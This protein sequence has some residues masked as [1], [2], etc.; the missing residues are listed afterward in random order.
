MF[1]IQNT[2]AR[3]WGP[4][5]RVC[6]RKNPKSPPKITNKISG[7]EV[8]KHVKI[9]AH[10]KGGPRSRVCARKNSKSPPPFYPTLKKKKKKKKI[11]PWGGEGGFPQF[12]FNIFHLVLP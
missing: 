11:P 10:A 2:G 5:S 8:R 9:L 1:S 6:A 12:F 4:L 3:Q 7:G